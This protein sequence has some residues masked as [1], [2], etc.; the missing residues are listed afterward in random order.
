LECH[1]KANPQQAP[2]QQLQ[3]DVREMR[4]AADPLRDMK[5]LE[6]KEVSDM[7]DAMKIEDATRPATSADFKKIEGDAAEVVKMEEQQQD[8]A[9]QSLEQIKKISKSALQLTAST[10]LPAALKKAAQPAFQKV[11]E[12]K[13]ALSVSTKTSH[14]EEK[15]KKIESLTKKLEAQYPNAEEELGESKGA[16]ALLDGAIK[17]ATAKVKKAPTAKAAEAAASK[18]AGAA[19]MLAAAIKTNKQKTSVNDWDTTMKTLKNLEKAVIAGERADMAE[20]QTL[21]GDLA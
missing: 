8:L 14:T 18:P 20:V 10:T 19:S 6:K 21:E 9:L 5:R 4:E 7:Q 12:V 17:T 13:S 1:G 3:E 15:A 16:A 11:E 2:T